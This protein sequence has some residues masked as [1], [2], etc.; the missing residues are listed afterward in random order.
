MP[1]V[2]LAVLVQATLKG[3]VQ[4]LQKQGVPAKVNKRPLGIRLANYHSNIVDVDEDRSSV[5]WVFRSIWLSTGV[6]SAKVIRKNSKDLESKLVASIQDRYEAIVAAHKYDVDEAEAK[7]TAN[8]IL[9]K[10]HKAF[11]E[12][13]SNI[14][15]KMSETDFSFCIEFNSLTQ[16]TAIEILRALKERGV[17]VR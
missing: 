4:E 3:V 8:S 1:L 11:P 16:E 9:L 17:K 10:I 14:W 6:V 13:T 7:D 2:E 12:Y 5:K 15:A